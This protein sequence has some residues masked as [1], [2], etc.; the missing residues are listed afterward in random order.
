[1]GKSDVTKTALKCSG[2]A[3]LLFAI[4]S[5]PLTSQ[6]FDGKKAN[7]ENKVDYA[8]AQ[9]DILKF[10]TVVNAVINSTFS[11]SPFAVV[12]KAKG[13]YLEGYGVNFAFLVN[14]HRAVINTPFGQVRRSG[15]AVTPELKKQRIEELKD[16]LIQ[17]L[18]QNGE[19]FQQLQQGDHITITAFI[20]DRNFPDEPSGN[21]TIV[22]ST[23]KKD[24]DEL[25][26]KNDSFKEFKQ[27]MKIIEY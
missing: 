7:S 10:E 12:Q 19:I 16:N 20:E 9:Q 8:S 22:L 23:L 18:Y 17:L 25:G 14:I 4:F 5:F 15:F 21:K 27:R 6:S 3:L 26:N 1:M 24:L 11:S 2:A 13:V